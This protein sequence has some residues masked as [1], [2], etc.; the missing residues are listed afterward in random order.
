M[1]TGAA[2]LDE[3]RPDPAEGGQI[4][5]ALGVQPPGD[6]RTL[7]RQQPVGADDL[8]GRL[9]TDEQV[10][11]VRVERVDV[12]ARLRAGQQGAQLPGEDVVP[13]PLRGTHVL[14]VPGEGDGVAGGGRGLRGAV[15]GQYAGHGI[16]WSRAGGGERCRRPLLCPCRLSCA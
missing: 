16:S 5:L 12:E 4:E 9:L 2:D 13:Q 6:R 11:A 7:R 3:F 10:V 8:A 1:H 14:L 15:D